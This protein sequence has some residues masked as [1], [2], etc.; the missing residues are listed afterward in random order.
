MSQ[1]EGSFQVLSPSSLF[2]IFFCIPKRLI[3]LVRASSC[4]GFRVLIYLNFMCL[5][6]DWL[7]SQSLPDI[8]L[9]KFWRLIAITTQRYVGCHCS[10]GTNA[11]RKD[12]HHR[13]WDVKRRY[14]FIWKLMMESLELGHHIFLNICVYMFMYILLTLRQLI[15][16]DSKLPLYRQRWIRV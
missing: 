8:F 3:L 5:I 7:I 1:P 14:I 16:S 4:L 10:R 6:R 9:W 13:R 11:K 2:E 15:F 12:K